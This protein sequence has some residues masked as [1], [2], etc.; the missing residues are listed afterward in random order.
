MNKKYKLLEKTVQEEKKYYY[1][2]TVTG[3][4][5][6]KSGKEDHSIG[7]MEKYGTRE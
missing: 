5:N 7:V 6:N 3:D 1:A 2:I 4:G